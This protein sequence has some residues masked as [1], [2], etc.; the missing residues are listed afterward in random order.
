MVLGKCEVSVIDKET[1]LGVDS[2]TI[3]L[4]PESDEVLAFNT[5]VAGKVD[6]EA[7]AGQVHNIVCQKEGYKRTR[8]QLETFP[9]QNNQLIVEM[10]KGE[11]KVK[12]GI[13]KGTFSEQCNEE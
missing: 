8:V 2:V 6:I 5:S 1:K 13:A 3:H 10:E 9:G 12:E 7:E 11:P 4:N